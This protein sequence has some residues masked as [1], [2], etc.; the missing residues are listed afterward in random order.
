MKK[1]THEVDW[2]KDGRQDWETPPD[3]FAA[4][5]AE[6]N[7]TVDGA[8]DAENALLPRHWD[9]IDDGLGQDW[10]GERVFVNPPFSESRKWVEKASLRA[11]TAVLLVP[12][13]FETRWWDHYVVPLAS[14]VR[15]VQGQVRFLQGGE[16]AQYRAPFPVAIVVFRPVSERWP[17]LDQPE[18][19]WSWS[20]PGREAGWWTP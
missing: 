15:L 6:F 17:L 4:L 3:L 2:V 12:A 1:R 10:A 13:S 9:A 19:T 7:F 14:E 5:H 11:G 8:S 20:W 18:T 16:P